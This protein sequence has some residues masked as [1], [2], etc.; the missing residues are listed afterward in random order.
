ME[1]TIEK[2]FTRAEVPVEVTWNLKDLFESDQ[3]WESELGIIEN[4]IASVTEFKGKLHNGSQVLLDCLNAQEKLYM[5]ITKAGTY[6]S[7]RKSADGTD[8]A[9]QA[10]A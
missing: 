4:E 2:R 8:P 3:L 6:A 5:R 1:K 7:L 10:D 9:N